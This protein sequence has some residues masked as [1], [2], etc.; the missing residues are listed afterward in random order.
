[1]ARTTCGGRIWSDVVDAVGGQ[2]WCPGTY[3]LSATIMDR[4]R[5][6]ALK[7]PASPFGTATFTV[8]P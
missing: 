7:H 1:M 4:G 6:G 3:H 5:Y 2:S 8:K